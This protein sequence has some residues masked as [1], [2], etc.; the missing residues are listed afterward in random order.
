MWAQSESLLHVGTLNTSVTEHTKQHSL[1]NCFSIMISDMDM[2]K[3]KTTTVDIFFF[4][5]TQLSYFLLC[6]EHYFLNLIPR[7]NI[8]IS[9]Y[10]FLKIQTFQKDPRACCF[11][12]VFLV[13]CI[14]FLSPEP[15]IIYSIQQ[16]FLTSPVAIVITTGRTLNTKRNKKGVC[17]QY[18]DCGFM[19]S[20]NWEPIRSRLL[21]FQCS[22]PEI[23][24]L[25]VN[26]TH[27]MRNDRWLHN[28]AL[29]EHFSFWKWKHK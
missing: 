8:Y 24:N 29:S 18:R 11:W 26:E 2:T 4:P 3:T 16:H 12:V 13:Y 10:F 19:T 5:L 22:W 17:E 15:S 7:I 9:I 6:W 27:T 14:N 25:T 20:Q 28:D 23:V 21:S 1:I